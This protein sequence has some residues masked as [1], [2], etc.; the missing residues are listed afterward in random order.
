MWA[1]IV[2]IWRKE[3]MDSTRDK[4]AFRQAIYM[5]LIIGIVYAVMN[6]LINSAM[7]AK[8]REPITIPVQGLEYT[9]PSFTNWLNSFGITLQ[10]FQGDLPTT[11]RRG[12]KEAGIIFP[13]DFAARLSAEQPISLTLLINSTAG[14]IFGGRFSSERLDLAINTFNTQQSINRLKSRNLDPALLTPINIDS[15]ELATSEQLA[16]LFATFMLPILLAVVLAQGGIF[17]AIDVTAGEKERGTLEALFVTP[18]TDLEILLGKLAAVF[19]MTVIPLALTFIAFWAAGS[20]LPASVTNG[21]VLPFSVVVG[22][23]LVGLPLALFV[24]TILMIV[25]I[26]T[27]AFKDAQ[28]ALSPIILGVMVPAM[29]AAFAPPTNSAAF[30]IPIYGA[31]AVVSSMASGGIMPENAILF[32]TIGSF[33][34]AGVTLVIAM[35]LF[36]RER[37]LYSM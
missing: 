25:S 18:A 2:N 32:S 17:I 31:S 24:N 19:T 34:A 26:R 20:L 29:V 9:S 35:R 33:A 5:P 3:L 13:P 1:R 22:A 28:S 27:K 16:G 8:A 7:M 10:P 11:I 36:N 21:A 37:V 15:R 12:E 30:L 23:I 14:G 6:P 4:R